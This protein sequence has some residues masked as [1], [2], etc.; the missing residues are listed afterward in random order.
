MCDEIVKKCE[1]SKTIYAHQETVIYTMEG[2]CMKL[3][4]IS[5]YTGIIK[6]REERLPGLF[7]ES[8]PRPFK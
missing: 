6:E 2:R 3:L 1:E 5:S 4:T 7:P 8:L